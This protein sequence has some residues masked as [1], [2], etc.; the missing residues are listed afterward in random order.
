[1]NYFERNFQEFWPQIKKAL[2]RTY[3][4]QNSYFWTKLLLAACEIYSFLDV[5]VHLI[6]YFT[7]KDTI[8]EM[9]ASSCYESFS[10]EHIETIVHRRVL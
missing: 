1:M 2:C 6:A 3:V 9:I 8:F 4:L 5:F 7:C 10:T